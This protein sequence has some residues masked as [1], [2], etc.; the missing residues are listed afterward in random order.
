MLNTE[1]RILNAKCTKATSKFIHL[2]KLCLF[3][4]LKSLI[5]FHVDKNSA[6]TFFFFLFSFF[7]RNVI[8]K[9][10]SNLS[11]EKVKQTGTM[12]HFSLLRNKIDIEFISITLND[13][14]CNAVI[15]GILWVLLALMLLLKLSKIFE[16]PTKRNKERK[17][18]AFI[19]LMNGNNEILWILVKN[20]IF[21]F[22][23]SYLNRI[24]SIK[25]I[26]S[27]D[28][29]RHQILNNE[30]M[31]Q[32]RNNQPTNNNKRPKYDDHRL[33]LDT[34]NFPLCDFS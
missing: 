21:T 31:K 11:A 14:F 2:S 26:R 24:S 8:E 20:N 1:C 9:C 34:L 3:C 18:K 29:R 6:N 16:Q 4:I 32:Q 15:A 30:E 22:S 7:C 33:K 23:F 17:R 10:Y 5:H 12:Y 27:T 13:P 28:D 19:W 25:Y